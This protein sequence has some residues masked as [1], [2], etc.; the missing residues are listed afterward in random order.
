VRII[1][2]FSKESE[3]GEVFFNSLSYFCSRE[4][5]SVRGDRNEGTS[6][7]QPSG[8][9]VGFNHTQWRSMI[10]PNHA[11]N[12][13]ALLDEIFIFCASEIFTQEL[14]ERFGAVA[15]IEIR[16][17]ESI[18]RRVR[19]VLP[20]KAAFFNRRV[21][22]YNPTKG[23]MERWALPDL[24]ATSKTDDYAWQREYRF[25]FPSPRLWNL[26]RYLWS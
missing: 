12:A 7:Y 6:R 10:L 20:S 15:C 9:L 3:R 5:G 21:T 24:I 8:G 18:C 19:R 16:N 17:I 14:Q 26:R 11:F 1:P 4:E 22:Y 2:S 23:P 13:T 25:I